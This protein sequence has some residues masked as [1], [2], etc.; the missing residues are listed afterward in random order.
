M[1]HWYVK[2]PQNQTLGP[3]TEEEVIE[4]LKSGF[5]L[6]QELVTKSNEARWIPITQHPAFFDALIN[7]MDRELQEELAP[8]NKEEV[9]NTEDGQGLDPKE[10]PLWKRLQVEPPPEVEQSPEEGPSIKPPLKF[11]IP[12]AQ[13][14]RKDESKKYLFYFLSMVAVTVA[15]LFFYQTGSNPKKDRIRLKPVRF[16][17]TAD[18][19]AGNDEMLKKAIVHFRKHTINDYLKAQDEL[20]TLVEQNSKYLDAMGFLCMTYKELWPYS[21]QD[22]KDIDTIYRVFRQASVLKASSASA[23]VC[24]VI[25]LLTVGE[26]EKAKNYMEDALRREPDLLFF[27]QLMGD[28][29]EQQRKYSTAAYYFQ[30]VVD[31]WPPPVWAKPLLQIARTQRK[32]KR[33]GEALES[34]QLALKYFPE[35][36]WAQLELGVLEFEAFRQSEKAN[37]LILKALSLKG[38]FPAEMRAEGYFVLAQIAL[39]SGYKKKALEYANQAFSVDSG[40][41][42]IKEF[43]LNLGGRSALENVQID[44][45]NMLYLGTQYMKLGNYFAAQAE[46]RLAFEADPRNALAA[47]H[48]G[49]SLWELNQST[50]AIKWI[51]KAIQADPGLISAY[52][53]LS[54]YYAYKHN[55][56]G[57]AQIL[58]NISRRYP[59]NNEIFRGY[60][61]IEYRRGNLKMAIQYAQKALDA[62]PMD[63][64]ALQ[65]MAKSYVDLSD[66][67]NAYNFIWRSLEVDPHTPENHAI[68]SKVLAGQS[69][70]NAAVD[71]L[72]QKIE[73]APDVILYRKALADIFIETKNWSGARALLENILT[74]K[75]EDKA[76]ILSLAFVYQQEGYVNR[77]LEMY[78]MAASFDPLDPTPLYNAG[79]LYM[80]AGNYK[81]AMAQF[82]R[83]LKI[84]KN[85]PRVYSQIGRA[86]L[87]SKDYEKALEMAKREKDLNPSLAEPYI[88]SAEAYYKQEQY[89]ECASEYQKAI[90]RRS[91]GTEIYIQMARCYRLGGALDPA[92]QMLDKAAQLESGNAEIY[93]ELGAVYHMQGLFQQAYSA[94]ERYLHLAPN[95]T[96]REVVEKIMKEL[97]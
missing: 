5:F 28:L 82:E 36:P 2:T 90:M 21:Y 92:I 69:G 8:K 53:T 97:Q 84:N 6:G 34:Y 47:Y 18:I 80:R 37:N 66:Y 14:P 64:G 81:Y 27:N 59:N 16:S 94:Y 12:V 4:K 31:L 57:A 30:K 71:Y 83:V 35:H 75:K 1:Q 60:A 96:D 95:S 65:T 13:A 29:L 19:N 49:Q 46:F 61:N 38:Q 67:R 89:Q 55:Y 73:E 77:A 56:E 39:Q 70:T 10:V 72:N 45:G 63:V 9:T 25:Y 78:L 48:A 62:Y 11:Q 86:A 93:K 68:Y 33:Y 79:E 26:Y 20:V 40:N 54:D 52:V 43:I 74:V 87:E 7:E 76:T 44:S 23:G 32:L 22:S 24:Y 51:E 88:L 58:K 91:Q 17:K 3:L 41:T 42:A 50:E 85:F 15:F